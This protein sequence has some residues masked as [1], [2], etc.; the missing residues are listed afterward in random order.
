MR[1][2]FR[3]AVV[4]SLAAGLG[5]PASA[6]GERCSRDALSIDGIAVAARFCVPSGAAS[7]SLSVTETFRAQGKTIVKTTPIA[8]VAGALTSRTID[9]IDLGPIGPK[10][11]L[12]MTLAYRAGSVE[13]E[14]ALALPGAIPIK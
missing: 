2:L 8:V 4:L 5:F 9:D 3:S 10:R 14:H 7:N 6:Q 11:T 13:L 12:H 1:T